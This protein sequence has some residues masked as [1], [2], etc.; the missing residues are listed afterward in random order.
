M[1]FL[2]M[3]RYKRTEFDEDEIS[4]VSNF[5]ADI[6]TGIS[7]PSLSTSGNQLNTT[8]TQD[9]YPHNHTAPNQQ[10]SVS[11]YK[12]YGID[13]NRTRKRGCWQRAS[14]FEK[15]LIIIIGFLSIVIGILVTTLASQTGETNLIH[16]KTSNNYGKF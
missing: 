10:P 5:P 9:D 2:K 11:F 12:P 13:G 14:H 8:D 7:N 6:V 15:L 4:D 3:P 1:F 16:I